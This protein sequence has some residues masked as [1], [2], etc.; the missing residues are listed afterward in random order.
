[1]NEFRT[2]VRAVRF[3]NGGEL[4]MLPSRREIASRRTAR[5]LRNDVDIAIDNCGDD[6]A[7]FAM[8]V[9]LAG[10]SV[11]SS[12]W[13]DETSVLTTPQ[14]PAIVADSIRKVLTGVEINRALG[15]DDDESA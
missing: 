2:R 6:M 11:F 5:R 9:W 13:V 10:G 1:M 3:K 4:R 14:I 15:R 8:T 7:G 12:V